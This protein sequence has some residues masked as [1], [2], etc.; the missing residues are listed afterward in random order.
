MIEW[1]S[2]FSVGNVA[3]CKS[4]T[5]LKIKSFASI[6]KDFTE[7]VSYFSLNFQNLGRVIF[8]EHFSF[9]ACLCI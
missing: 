4:A 8:K 9:A 5:L 3:G 2:S 7:I 1:R 6:F